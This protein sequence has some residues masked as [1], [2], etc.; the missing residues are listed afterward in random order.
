[1]KYTIQKLS[2]I[3]Y[4]SHYLPR[5]YEIVNQ[6]GRCD[7]CNMMIDYNKYDMEY[8]EKTDYEEDPKRFTKLLG[9]GDFI[10]K[11]DQFSFQ[12]SYSADSTVPVPSRESDFHGVYPEKMTISCS[13]GDSEDFEQFIFDMIEK[14]RISQ[15]S[16][17]ES[18][19]NVMRWCAQ[20]E[21]WKREGLIAKRS[22]DTI[23]LEEKIRNELFKDLDQFTSAETRDFYK[24]HSIPFKRSYL[25]HG[26]PGTGKSSII[27]GIASRLNRSIYRVNLVAPRLNDDS[28]QQA[29]REVT[30]DG[31]VVFEDIDSLFGY[32]R[33]KTEVSNV[34]FSGLLNSLDGFATNN[35]GILI[36]FTT[37]HPEKLDDALRR[38]GRIDAEFDIKSCTK[39]QAK[40]MFLRFYPGA[41]KEAERFS[42]SAVNMTPA[43]LQH[44]FVCHRECEAK[45]A[46]VIRNTSK[47]NA[48]YS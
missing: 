30:K 15:Y 3:R 20:G 7:D 12:L 34:T 38:K 18:N 45:E 29:I 11:A 47:Q 33:E 13:E 26:K 10:I 43:E 9:Y 46:A 35:N 41:M 31:L 39:A 23:I 14:A 6:E 48:L 42:E 37:N 28:L 21:Y 25:L 5:S 2:I 32:H 1:M 22:F 27:H 17:N 8:T 40:E 24:K 4:I 44:H 16:H 19:V 36:V